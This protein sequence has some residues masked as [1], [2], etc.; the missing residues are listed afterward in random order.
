MVLISNVIKDYGIE[1]L[2]KEEGYQ[3]GYTTLILI[4]FADGMVL[5]ADAED[6]FFKYF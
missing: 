2:V 1:K 4:T 5:I 3:M 6:I